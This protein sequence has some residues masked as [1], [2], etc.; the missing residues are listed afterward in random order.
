MEFQMVESNT[1][2]STSDAID[3]KEKVAIELN[4]SEIEVADKVTIEEISTS[5][6]EIEFGMTNE[7]N[8][9]VATAS[10]SAG[11]RK[12]R[13]EI[14]LSSG[15]NDGEAV[16]LCVFDLRRGQN[17]GQELDKI[18][19]FHP[20]DLPLTTH[21]F[22]IGFSEGFVTFIRIFSLEAAIDVWS[23]VQILESSAGG[24]QSATRL[25]FY[26]TCWCPQQFLL[27]TL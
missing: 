16:K 1:K 19:F 8:S 4:D 22:V 14:V 27:M 15:S 2:V 26:R 25:Q 13:L 21:L 9:G 11:A 20:A 24:T 23:L 18:L 10:T 6:A 12:V 7:A 5:K 17:E 3:F